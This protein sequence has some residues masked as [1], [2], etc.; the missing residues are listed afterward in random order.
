LCTARSDG[1]SVI[2]SLAIDPGQAGKSQVAQLSSLLAGYRLYASRE[3]GS[4]WSRAV[5]VA[6]QIESGN[7][8]VRRGAWHQAFMDELSAFPQG[9]KDDQ[10]DALSRAFITLSDLPHDGRRLFVPFNAR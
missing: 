1:H 10:V 9:T 8:A 5:L 2:I 3:Q 4:K 7:F 6:A